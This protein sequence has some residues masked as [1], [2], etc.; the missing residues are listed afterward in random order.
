LDER[1]NRV[2]WPTWFETACGHLTRTALTP[3]ER[4]W[5]QQSG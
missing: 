2:I 5:T 1:P 3:E 4:C